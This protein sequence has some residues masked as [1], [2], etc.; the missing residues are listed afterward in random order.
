MPTIIKQGQ[1]GKLLR[2]MVS[3]DLADH[4]AEAHEVVAGARQEAGRIVAEARLEARRLRQEARRRGHAEGLEKGLA[5]GRTEGHRQAL[6]EATERFNRE[7]AE[8]A[9]SM[10]A[11]IDA[12][13]RQRQDLLI[14]AN[15]DLLEF[16]VFVAGKITHRIG[17]ID[18]DTAAG[19]VR[20]ALRL[21]GGKTDL[22]VRANSAD[23]E[24]LRRFAAQRVEEFGDR[25]HVALVQD[26]S[27]S[28][29]GAKVTCG[30]TE[31]DATLETQLEQITTLLLGSVK[32]QATAEGAEPGIETEE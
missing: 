32:P 9:A 26:D 6:A 2:R 31:I 10:S 24:A 18:R 3:F 7:H 8:L 29:G 5:E 13:E 14:A 28:P 21:V 23:L 30:R 20:Q 22:T 19:A 17:C 11:V 16:A 4:L 15:R 1:Q 27:I 12:F 25:A